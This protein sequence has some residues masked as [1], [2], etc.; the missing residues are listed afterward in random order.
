[1]I[2]NEI[3]Y[4]NISA[5]HPGVYIADLIDDLNMTQK[6]FAYRLGVT[7]KSLS[8]LVNGEDRL[9][10]EHAFKLSKMTGVSAT[11]WM[12]LQNKFDQKLIEINDR[13]MKQDKEICQLIDFKYFK[14]LRL[15]EERR[16]SLEEKIAVIRRILN[17]SSLTLLTEFQSSVSYRNPSRKFSEK[18]TVNSNIM[19]EIATNNARTAGQQKFDKKKL[20]SVLPEIRQMTL[21]EPADFYPK[22]KTILGEC[23]IVL[24][25]LPNLR[26]AALNGAVKKFKDGSVLLLITDR[27]KSS[28]IF[29]F[30]IWH[31]F[32]HLLNG[33][34][35]RSY[36]SG[37][38]Y[39]EVERKADEFAAD[40]LIDPLHYSQFSKRK[41][42]SLNSIRRFAKEMDIHPSIVLGRLQHDF[43]VPRDQ[44]NSLKVKYVAL[45]SADR[46]ST[47]D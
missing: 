46:N 10:S 13:K 26:N 39:L 16:Y 28:D 3:H 18:N 15:I 27:N 17:L 38:D 23:G 6:E 45:V 25:L 9:S 41:Q 32:A 31:E 29:W 14:D 20:E 4:D 11:A 8:K 37:E 2:R 40:H 1:M 42:F 44:F 24:V 47:G 33:D 35:N 22:L 43:L 7:E 30:S 5:F 21:Q 34:L 36:E 19:L 12:N